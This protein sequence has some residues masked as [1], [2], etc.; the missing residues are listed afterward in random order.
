MVMQRRHA[1]RAQP[2]D[3]PASKMSCTGSV[4]LQLLCKSNLSHSSRRYTVPLSLLCLPCMCA[5]MQEASEPRYERGTGELLAP[6]VQD[7]AQL[8]P[9]GAAAAR[10]R[11]LA[12]AAVGDWSDVT[13]SE[14]PAGTPHP[15]R[16]RVGL[17]KCHNC[18]SYKHSVNK[19]PEP[20]DHV[21][22]SNTAT[23]SSCSS[24][25]CCTC[26]A[27]CRACYTGNRRHCA[28]CHVNTPVMLL[29]LLLQ[30]RVAEARNEQSQQ[31]SAGRMLQMKLRY[32]EMPGGSQSGQAH[33]EVPLPGVISQELADALGE[34]RKGVHSRPAQTAAGCG[35]A[36]VACRMHVASA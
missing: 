19:C 3:N 6:A 4:A 23:R 7:S 17:N 25:M 13:A 12:Q 11:Q 8:L 29:Y 34:Q 30:K 24:C 33:A 15:K 31:N 36:L 18:G 27:V 20:Y 21:R 35:S 16:R 10:R 32:F 28:A 26:E 14:G 5:C 2:H 9:G 1:G 22:L